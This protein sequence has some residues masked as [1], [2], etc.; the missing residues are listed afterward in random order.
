MY[1][2]YKSFIRYVENNGK[3][4]RVDFSFIDVLKD[5]IEDYPQAL[6]LIRG[7]HGLP[8]IAINGVI[9]FYGDINYEQVYREILNYI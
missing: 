8:Y 3:A 4:D 6:A 2:I 9:K 7:K 5:R 1:K